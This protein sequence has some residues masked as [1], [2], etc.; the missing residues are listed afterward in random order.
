LALT[1]VGAVIPAMI[2]VGTAALGVA[3]WLAPLEE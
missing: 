3:T 1:V 2:F